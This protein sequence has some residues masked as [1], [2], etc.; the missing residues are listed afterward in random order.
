MM[1]HEHHERY[2]KFTILD[3][4]LFKRALTELYM[5]STRQILPRRLQH[6]FRGIDGD[7]SLA[8][9]TQPLADNACSAA[10]IADHCFRINQRSESSQMTCRSEELLAQT[11]PL[12]GG[13]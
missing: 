10:E 3:R 9:Q 6:L 7:H 11:I 13:G 5:L 8:E 4:Q 2:V 12:S 1:Q